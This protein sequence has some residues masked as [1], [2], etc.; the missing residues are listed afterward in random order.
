MN[1]TKLKLIPFMFILVGLGSYFY[2]TQKLDENKLL[3]TGNVEGTEVTITAEVAGELVAINYDEG[4]QVSVLDNLFE[5]DVTDYDIKLSQLQIQQEIA[6]LNLKKI[7]DGASQEDINLSRSNRNSVSKQLSSAR[8]NYNHLKDTYGDMEVLFSSGALSKSDL[9]K[10]KL[11][12]DQAYAGMKSLESQLSATQASLDKVLLGVEEETISI[13]QNQ[14]NLRALEIK[15]LEN[16]IAKGLKKSPISGV[17]QTVNYEVGEYVGPGMKVISIINMDRLTIDV[18][19]REQNLYEVSVGD[20]VKITEDF[21][22]GKEVVGE[23]VAISSKAE[24]TPKNVESKES[25]QEMVFKTTI[26]VTKGQ[27]YLKPGMF[28]DVD[29]Q[30]LKE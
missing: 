7:T 3:F 16:T 21:L 15:N 12:K 14:I 22:A 19:V 8:L 1:K 18:Y 9:D 23:I 11:Q 20:Q 26:E 28:V 5:V 30:D 4:N 25:K 13:A 2:Q 10:A 29:M 6:E 27:E 17:I 24:F